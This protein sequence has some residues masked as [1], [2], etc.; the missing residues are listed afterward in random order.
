MRL[1][2]V[3]A[4]GVMLAASGCTSMHREVSAAN[5]DAV[6][7]AVAPDLAGT[8]RGTAFAVSGSSHLTATGV[9]LDI[10]PDGT[11]AWKSGGATKATETVVRRAT[12]WSSRQVRRRE[13]RGRWPSR[14][15]FS[16]AEIT[17]GVSAGTSFPALR[18]L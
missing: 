6:S 16:S 12:R 4:L 2:T 1:V 10:T 7:A 3:I 15:G 17:S 5:D 8:W 9:E 14:F 13:C 18:A 11:W